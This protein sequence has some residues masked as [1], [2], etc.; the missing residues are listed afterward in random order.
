MSLNILSQNVRGLSNREKQKVFEEQAQTLQTQIILIQEHMM[1]INN[2]I[3]FKNYQTKQNFRKNNEQG[4]GTAIAV[5][6]A[7]IS[8]NNNF[9]IKSIDLDVIGMYS[10][11]NK[12]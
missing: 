6:T 9:T 7:K 12:L 8:E 2:K 3:E 10:T 5:D 1:N 4:G 11:R